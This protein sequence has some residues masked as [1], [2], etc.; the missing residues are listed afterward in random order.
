MNPGGSIRSVARPA[1]L[2]GA[3]ISA[4]ESPPDARAVGANF[5]P[6]LMGSIP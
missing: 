4:S 5:P 3:C 6:G 2:T 1:L